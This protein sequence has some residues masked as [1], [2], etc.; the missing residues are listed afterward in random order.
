MTTETATG[1]ALEVPGATLRYDVRGSGPLV[2]LVPGGAADSTIFA[3]LVPHLVDD[4]TV[5]TFG[6]RGI[7]RSTLTGPAGEVAVQTQADD[8]HRL[9]AAITS[10]PARVF[11][12]SGGAVT[13]LELVTRHPEQVHTLVLHEPPLVELLP[14]RDELRVAMDALAGT[15]RTAGPDVAMREFLRISGQTV[16]PDEYAIPPAMRPAA[17]FFLQHMIGPIIRY[18]PDPTA[19]PPLAIGVGTGTTQLAHRAAMA[20]AA[21]LAIPTTPFPGEHIG[22]ATHASSAA[23]VLRPLLGS[24]A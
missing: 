11:A 6:P 19:L 1:Q 4:H 8:V 2:L 13:A 20:L 24:A 7:G 12:S 23:A 22:F 14:D 9:L 21:L 10:Q 3:A 16:R 18:R 5:V 15:C 17:E